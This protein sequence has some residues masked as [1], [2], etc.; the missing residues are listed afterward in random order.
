[1]FNAEL[2]HAL[3]KERCIQEFIMAGPRP[4]CLR[5]SVVI[6]CCGKSAAK[7][8]RK[9]VKRLKWLKDFDVPCAVVVDTVHLYSQEH[10]TGDPT[11]TI[12]A[13]L[14]PNPTTLCG[15]R[16]RKFSLQ[17]NP[18]P[19]CTLGGLILVEGFPFGMTVEHTFEAG[20]EVSGFQGA[21]ESQ[22][23]TSGDLS[24][25]DAES[26][27]PFISF[28]D[29]N[30]GDTFENSF[31]P[32][33]E[34]SGLPDVVPI[35]P[36]Y[37]DPV[38]HQHQENLKAVVYRRIGKA[39][40]SMRRD[41][42]DIRHSSDWALIEIDDPSCFFPNKVKLPSQNEPKIIEDM[43]PEDFQAEGHVDVVLVGR[44]G[45]SGR[46]ISSPTSFKVGNSVMD[47]RLIIMDNKLGKHACSLPEYD[48]CADGMSF[49]SLRGFWS[50]GFTRRQTL[51]TCHWRKR[52]SAMGLHGANSPD[53]ARNQTGFRNRRHLPPKERK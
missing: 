38:A 17:D 47:T 11:S 39:L 31:Q 12:E 25:D 13:Q 6:T 28:D 16:I 42:L 21:Y 4:N 43:V 5:A 44:G 41:E 7:R 33:H 10:Q 51:R 37:D 53:N 36:G 23:V 50:L 24:S 34:S 20:F 40:P 1:M 30:D 3:R 27:S 14:P 29:E 32:L 19:F 52:A 35:D 45:A 48:F 49:Y 46:L 22:I 26:E 9:V 8:V 2:W 15:R 18:G